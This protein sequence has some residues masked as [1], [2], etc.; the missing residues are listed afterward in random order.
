ME[1]LFGALWTPGQ[2]IRGPR[3]RVNSKSKRVDPAA[4]R[5]LESIEARLRV[6]R[7]TCLTAQ[8]AL[9]RLDGDYTPDIARSLEWGATDALSVEC[10]RLNGV[11]VHL[12]RGDPLPAP[13]CP[14]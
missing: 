8:I 2:R 13:R 10:A 11:I 7:A 5:E 3:K 9:E 6:A 4:A 14:P 1:V 12:M